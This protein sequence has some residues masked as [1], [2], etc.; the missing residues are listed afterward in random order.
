MDI[1]DFFSFF[2]EIVALLEEQHGIAAAILSDL[3]SY[4]TVAKQ[5]CM[6]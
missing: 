3:F 6:A 4:L 1:E 2:F 5:Q